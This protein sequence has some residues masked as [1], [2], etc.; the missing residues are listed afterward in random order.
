MKNIEIY[1]KLEESRSKNIGVNRIRTG[2]E[3]AGKMIHGKE[4]HDSFKARLESAL[5]GEVHTVFQRVINIRD[6]RGGMYSFLAASLDRGPDSLIL[7]IEELDNL[8]ISPGDR[9]SGSLDGLRIGKYLIEVWQAKA[10]PLNLPDYT[11]NAATLRLRMAYAKKR[12]EGFSEEDRST[13][14]LSMMDRMLEERRLL[15]KE[16]MRTGDL[17][18]CVRLGKKLIGLGQGLTPSGDDILLGLFCVVLMGNSPLDG[19]KGFPEAVLDGAEG[20]TN[21]LSLWGLKRAAKGLVR[22]K[23]SDF[24]RDLAQGKEITDSLESILDIG[25]SS[26]KDITTGILTGFELITDKEENNGN[27]D[28]D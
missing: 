9:I 10:Y 4:I 24:V 20:L 21:D 16:A 11:A 1:R 26:G 15:L 6:D 23:V 5:V 12:M 3:E 8:G 25:H 17:E 14:F 18:E 7:D 2:R 13:P 19:L 28:N 22:E 27:E